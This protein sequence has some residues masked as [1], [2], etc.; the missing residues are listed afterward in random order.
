MLRLEIET[1]IEL[2]NEKLAETI[3]RS[4]E[5]DNIDIPQGV[6]LNIEVRDRR[7][8]ISITCSHERLLSCRSTLDEIFTLIN[9]IIDSIQSLEK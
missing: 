8:I 3:L 6:L 5:P 9:D 1:E 2:F 7:I 4:L